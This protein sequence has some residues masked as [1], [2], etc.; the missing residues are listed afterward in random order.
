MKTV[1]PFL[2]SEELNT[3]LGPLDVLDT[4]ARLT[5]AGCGRG[6]VTGAPLGTP[7]ISGRSSSMSWPCHGTQSRAETGYQDAK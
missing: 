2:N 4:A 5:P 1:A 7:A 3:E 6:P